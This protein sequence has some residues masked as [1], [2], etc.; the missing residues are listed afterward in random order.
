MEEIKKIDEQTIDEMK[1]KHHNF[2]K[3]EVK[4]WKKL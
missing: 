3:D 1:N 2:T 4:L